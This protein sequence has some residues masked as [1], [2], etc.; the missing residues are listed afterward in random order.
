MENGAGGLQAKHKLF[1]LLHDFYGDVFRDFI[2]LA[3]DWPH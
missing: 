1:K 2:P 3:I